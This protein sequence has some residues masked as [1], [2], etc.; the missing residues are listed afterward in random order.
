MLNTDD[1]NLTTTAGADIEVG[2]INANNAAALGDVVLTAAGAITDADTNSL[3]TADDFSFS[4][5]TNVGASAAKINTTVAE[6]LSGASTGT[7]D[8]YL[9]ETNDVTLTSLT[10]ADGL[11]DVTAGGKITA[12]SVSTTGGTNTD[13]ILL[14]TS[15]GDIE[16]G[17]ISASTLGD[18]S[19]SSAAAIT[20]TDTNSMV[21]ADQLSFDAVGAVGASAAK[22]NTTV[23]EVLS[24]A[25][26]GAGDIYL[27][28][29]NDVV[30]TSL[31]NANGLIDV[32]AG[33]K[34]TAV[35]VVTAGNADTDDINLTTTAG[36]DIEVGTINANNAAALGDVVLTAAG[37][38]TDADTNSLIT[39][40]DFSFSAG[41]NVGASAAKINT[42]VAEVLS[43][44]STGTGD[45][46]LNE[47]NDVTLT[48]LTNADG[49]IDVTAGGKITAVSVSTTGGT[50][51]D[52][53]LLTTSAGD[54]EVG[55]I[56]AS[57]LGDVSLSSAAAITDTDTNSMITADQLSFDAVG[58]VG[59]SAAKINTTV[60]EV[61]SGA[62]TGAGDIYLN[63]ANDVV[64]TSL[65]NANG[66]I[67]VTA[68]GKITAVS[69]VTAGN[70]DTDD[71]NLTT[72]AGADIE[73]GTINANNAAALGDVVLTA[74]GAITDADTNSAITADDFSFSAG[75]NVGASAAKINTTVAEVLSGASTGT[76]DIYLN[77]TN[78]VTLTSLTNADGLIDV[79]AGGKITAVSVVT[80][81]N[82]DTDDINLTT[83]AG[84]D[85]EVGTINANNAAALG[86]VV[87]TAAGAITDAA[88]TVTGDVLTLTAATAIGA[89]GTALTTDAVSITANTT[90]N[91][92]VI[93]LDDAADVILTDVDTFD[94]NI[95]VSAGGSLVLTTID[96][97]DDTVSLT[98]GGSITDNDDTLT[99]ITAGTLDLNAATGIGA[100][101]NAMDIVAT[102]LTADTTAGVVNLSN[103]PGAAVTVN[104]MT[105]AG[106]AITY[107]QEAG[108]LTIGGNVTTTGAGTITL[109]AP[110]AIGQSA[111]TVISTN[112]GAI[113]IRKSS[114]DDES[115]SFIMSDDSSILLNSGAVTI[116]ANTIT[117]DNVTTGSSVVLDADAAAGSITTQTTGTAGKITAGSLSLAVSAASG[118]SITIAT[119]IDAITA[120]NV[121]DITI[122]NDDDIE[123]TGITTAA[124]YDGSVN[125][126]TT[127]GDIL[128]S[129][130][131]NA[132]DTGTITLAAGGTDRDVI[133]EADLISNGALIDL[134]AAG[135]VLIGSNVNAGAGILEMKATAGS[136]IQQTA[137]VIT[138]GGVQALA[139]GGVILN[140]ANNQMGT[141]AASASVLVSLRDSDGLTV[142]TVG[143]TPTNGITTSNGNVGIVAGGNL[144]LAQ[145]INAGT[146]GVVMTASNGGTATISGAAKVTG[147]VVS[148]TADAGVSM[149]TAAEMIDANAGTGALTLVEDNT[150]WLRNLDAGA[151]G[152]D[153]TVA[154]DAAVTITDI[155]T[156]GSVEISLNGTTANASKVL[157]DGN[158]STDITATALTID[159]D[160]GAG[161][162]AVNGAVALNTDVDSL[163]VSATGNV[164]VTEASGVTLTSLSTTGG[165]IDVTAGGSVT[166]TSVTSTNGNVSIAS[167]GGLTAT[168]VQAADSGATGTYDV[169]LTNNTS[170][171]VTI[172]ALTADNDVTITS[173]GRILDAGDDTSI[174][175]T[176]VNAVLTAA[177]G[178]GAAGTN[179]SLETSVDDLDVTVTGSGG[180]DI[181]EASAV[182]LSDVDTANGEISIEA[183]GTITATDVASLT[184]NDAND[185]LLR[186]TGAGIVAGIVNAGTV[187]DVTL[188]AQGGAI[189]DIAGVVSADVLTLDAS[190]T[191]GTS[192]AA[193]TTDVASITRNATDTYNAAGDIYLAEDNAVVLTSMVT[194]NGTINITGGGQMTATSVITGNNNI[195]LTT[196]SSGDVLIGTMT[197]GNGTVTIDADGSIVDDAGND[198]IVDIT[199]ATINLTAGGGIGQY[200]VANPTTNLTGHLDVQ[201]TDL[202]ALATGGD[203]SIEEVTDGINVKSVIATGAGYDVTLVS[204]NTMN[205]DYVKAV[206]DTVKLV[207]GSGD[208]VG[209]N[210]GAVASPDVVG[211]T[212][213]LASAGQVV[214]LETDVENIDL[215]S[216]GN[217]DVTINAGDDVVVNNITSTTG[218]IDVVTVD[219]DI[220]VDGSITASSGHISLL[221]QSTADQPSERRDIIVNNGN[222]LTAQD[223]ISINST[224]DIRLGEGVKLTS[225]T[226]T[227]IA[228]DEI[229]Q[230]GTSAT[231]G[232]IIAT[233]LGVKTAGG[234]VSLMEGAN[235]IGT[236]TVLATG[237]VSINNSTAL[238]VGT[239]DLDNTATTNNQ[240]GIVSNNGDI[241]VTTNGSLALAQ[242]VNAG[243][244]DV[245]FT[246]NGTGSISYTNSSKVT[247]GNL[248]ANAAT[249]VDLKTAVTDSI[250][251]NSGTG[252]FKITEDDAVFAESIT[253]GGTVEVIVLGDGDLR[254]GAISA[255]TG[256]QNVTFDLQGTSDIL[257][258]DVDTT[259][260]VGSTLTLKDSG[261]GQVNGSADIQT[262]VGSLVAN[263]SGSLEVNESNALNLTVTNASG[264]AIT[265][266][267]GMT[268]NGINDAAAVTLTASGGDLTLQGAINSANTVS[269]TSTGSVVDNYTGGTD[270]VIAGNS[271]LSIT[272]AN[273]IG[274][275]GN[276]IEVDV[277]TLNAYSN[278]SG[279][280]YID[281]VG[282]INL[283][284]VKTTASDIYVKADSAITVGTVAAGGTGSVTLISESGS[285]ISGGTVTGTTVNLTTAAG[286]EIHG[287]TAT[288]STLNMETSLVGLTSNFT[289]DVPGDNFYL[290]LLG[291]TDGS[292]YTARIFPGTNLTTV[293][294]DSNIVR[295]AA[296]SD[297][298]TISIVGYSSILSA[299]LAAT[300][301]EFL[302]TQ[303]GP[304]VSSEA[305]RELELL[306]AKL[307]K[308]DIFREAPLAIY[309]D[310]G[311]EEADEWTE[312][313]QDTQGGGNDASLP[314]VGGTGVGTG[315]DDWG[316]TGG[317]DTGG[318]GNTGAGFEGSGAGIG[319]P[320][321]GDLGGSGFV[322]PENPDVEP[323]PGMDINTGDG[324]REA[325]P[326]DLG[327][328]E[329]NDDW[330]ES[331]GANN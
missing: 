228:G 73:V 101:G 57:T 155:A 118:D 197:A 162:L 3:I 9:N 10:N 26:T 296:S 107:T 112:S 194:N 123:V 75:T 11:I 245:S 28:E 325:G 135:D 172:G 285:N 120:S 247:G 86:D 116:R 278:T 66:L 199:A 242:A 161:N 284:S 159:N 253:A 171:D 231:T 218:N 275:S 79:T 268:V 15:A 254:V 178:V 5:G 29:A 224:D 306:L 104:S 236:L 17:T 16:V 160:S 124:G 122:V 130:A 48:S 331:D 136:I 262:T 74:A 55:T 303:T 157:D 6:V 208:I 105:T 189:T 4:A 272:A 314:G 188:D 91:A 212:L 201:V 287:M 216:T 226:V 83:T 149:V 97:A 298:G 81:G 175:I 219:G 21:T 52:D 67:D 300:L 106:S 77:E 266:G 207:T 2:T 59:A 213:S 139:G 60:A 113:T 127:D 165:T 85:I 286:G 257:D 170:G 40:D 320:G 326:N 310:I 241:A 96:G 246:A 183:A 132:D 187:G 1:I 294:P 203:I 31:T 250:T 214:T 221:T 70:A 200:D 128:V 54:I 89:V 276:P 258:D 144:S 279:D 289:A 248:T 238:T 290:N 192:T 126:S 217:V 315:F 293:P 18:V 156:T 39:A 147:G 261:D 58:A 299:S 173:A 264:T 311:G 220:I 95:T 167:V 140:S 234:M 152:V 243:T 222:S 274:V 181:V 49:L 323:G 309:I 34:I 283:D 318:I 259:R 211:G 146:G 210:L 88:G 46:Y 23:A 84:A 202:Y 64:L 150:V 108:N 281:A 33:G 110:G 117:L 265:A 319:A 137:G 176:G 133:L 41:T 174:D 51:T 205:V 209:T 329:D 330:T 19:L 195:N 193:L 36:A 252:N 313:N 37:A 269:L 169:T 76:G 267:G 43:G 8:I 92:G 280:I 233:N 47:T 103:T 179:T 68:G 239:V 65:T 24:G 87:L 134:D 102:T 182:T 304:Q 316:E 229:I 277:R 180:I 190:T 7:G 295:S 223:Y 177:T 302:Q 44:A 324:D 151:A 322:S 225:S 25:S 50:N 227:L 69:V 230:D 100:A 271:G 121:D 138:A 38:I 327:E 249:G 111:G 98:A 30:L 154:N 168:L 56:S 291:G 119:D 184:D 166:A 20:D 273:Y 163:S 196:S 255:G 240:S 301:A 114:A 237:D 93:V 131:I 62:S 256:S 308:E 305:Q 22:I 321:S 42:T 263:L 198:Q 63:E 90:T 235:A 142:G 270:I 158:A 297:I 204:A 244:G 45:I 12:V 78:D 288:A 206:G 61:L 71:I 317:T 232:G 35:S 153:V 27:N 145:A 141:V 185:I 215:A 312:S 251:G 94:G 99:D 13:D 82:A 164:S 292:G 129:T 125:I 148:A 260:I 328:E 32:T 143:S 191:I 53:I 115:T 282:S 186:S 14:T 72:T 80:A 307:L 109:E